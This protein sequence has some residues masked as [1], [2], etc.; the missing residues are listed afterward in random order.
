MV[1]FLQQALDLIATWASEWQLSISVNKCNL[2]NIGHCCEV[3]YYINSIELPQCRT[4]RDL[5]V[6]IASDLLSSHHIRE[7]TLKAHQRANHILRCF[8]SGD[9]K[10]LVKAFTL[11]CT[12]D[13]RI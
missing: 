3:K 4:C 13:P 1:Y 8:V 5:G 10:L 2:L 11:L 9:N 12:S 6:V 7:I